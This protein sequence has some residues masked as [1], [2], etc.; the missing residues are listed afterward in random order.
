VDDDYPGFDVDESF[1][2]SRRWLKIPGINFNHIG[3]PKIWHE[4]YVPRIP[5]R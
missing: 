2:R 1:D 4:Q 5:A 3:D